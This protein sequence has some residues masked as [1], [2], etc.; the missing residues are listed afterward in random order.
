MANPLQDL[1]ALAAA[2]AAAYAEKFADFD[3]DAVAVERLEQL[4]GDLGVPD[5]ALAELLTEALRRVVALKIAAGPD[6]G[7][8]FYRPGPQ[9]GR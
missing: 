1:A 5:M 8:W 9:V 6:A 3:A 2:I 4:L 7:P